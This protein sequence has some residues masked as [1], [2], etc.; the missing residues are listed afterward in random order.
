VAVKSAEYLVVSVSHDHGTEDQ[1]HH[2]ESERL[3]AI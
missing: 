2:E 3:Q 1:A